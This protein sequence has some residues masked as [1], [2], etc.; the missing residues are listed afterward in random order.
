[1]PRG[2][3]EFEEKLGGDW[4]GGARTS[5]AGVPTQLT[6]RRRGHGQSPVT[7]NLLCL[8]EEADP[9]LHALINQWTNV[10]W[11]HHMPGV[12]NNC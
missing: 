5:C 4:A 8:G 12:A 1:M 9:H 7:E 10:N 2:H 3:V 6:Q 11:P